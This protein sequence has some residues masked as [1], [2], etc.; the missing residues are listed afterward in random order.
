MGLKVKDSTSEEARAGV[1]VTSRNIEDL[2]DSKGQCNFQLKFAKDARRSAYLNVVPVKNVT[3]S[4]KGEDDRKWVPVIGFECRGMDVTGFHPE[5]CCAKKNH[6]FSSPTSAMCV[7][8]QAAWC[9]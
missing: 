4:L 2:K 9:S 7:M 3:R 8:R 5:V 6:S 1:R